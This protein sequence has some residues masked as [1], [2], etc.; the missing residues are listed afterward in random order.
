M[1]G[2]IIIFIILGRFFKHCSAFSNKGI[3]VNLPLGAGVKWKVARRLNVIAEWAIRFTPSD[4]LDGK[5]DVYGIK[6]SGLFKNADCYHAFQVSVTYD[7]WEKCKT[8]HQE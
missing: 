7:L 6:S 8:C 4:Y 2:I 1:N 5:A 3:T